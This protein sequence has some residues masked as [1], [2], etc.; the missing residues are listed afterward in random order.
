MAVALLPFDMA[1]RPAQARQKQV[2]YIRWRNSFAWWRVAALGGAEFIS[3]D[4]ASDA[5][6]LHGTE[7]QP[8]HHGRKQGLKPSS[9]RID[10][11][12]S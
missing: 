4:C 5:H 8:H 9:T 1:A 7:G 6:D 11:P 3:A 12:L 2:K 10:G